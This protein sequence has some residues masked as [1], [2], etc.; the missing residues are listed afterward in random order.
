MPSRRRLA[1]ISV[2]IALR[3]SPAPLGPGASARAPWWRSRP[4]P[5]GEVAPA[6]P[7]ISSLVPSE[8]TLAVSKKLMPSSSARWMNGRL[9][10]S[11]SVQGCAPRPAR[12]SSC[13]PGRSATPRD[14]WLPVAMRP[15]TSPRPPALLWVWGRTAGVC[16]GPV[17][18]RR[19]SRLPTRPGTAP[20]PGHPAPTRGARACWVNPR[21]GSPTAGQRGRPGPPP[22][23]GCRPDHCVRLVSAR[24]V[25]GGGQRAGTRPAVRTGRRPA[26]TGAAGAASIGLL[27]SVLVSGCGP[28]PEGRRT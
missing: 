27:I 22:F 18:K 14:P 20:R 23:P 9:A 10:S 19:V 7:T 8:Y 24:D 13:S 16:R 25:P 6:R 4:R 12:H 1:S 21:A 15:P 3:D 5:A 17:A 28:P 26:K 11:S 2:R